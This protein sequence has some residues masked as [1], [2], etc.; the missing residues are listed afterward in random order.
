MIKYSFY[1]G[2]R[3]ERERERESESDVSCFVQSDL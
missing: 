2:E 1:I 3:R